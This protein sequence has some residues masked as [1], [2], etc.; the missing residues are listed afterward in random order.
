MGK[1]DEKGCVME[2]WKSVP[3]EEYKDYEVSDL[4]RI[5][6]NGKILKGSVNNHGYR[7]IRLGGKKGFTTGIHRL[8]ALA[9]V[10]NDDPE[11]KTQCNHINELTTD[12]RAVNL[13]WMTPKE[14]SNWGTGR[15]RS[16]NKHKKA[17]LQLDMDDN[18]IACY[19]SATDAEKAGFNRRKIS[20]VCNGRKATHKGFKWRFE[21]NPKNVWVIKNNCLTLWPV[22]HKVGEKV[23]VNWLKVNGLDTEKR[24]GGLITSTPTKL[25][26]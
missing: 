10:P 21:N 18:I 1:L 7:V 25:T 6:H 24:V 11:H 19:A 26:N 2:H 23:A 4:G 15:S 22:G 20:D 14:N 17:I 5:R 13:N 9:F 16:D 3:I 8:V 12:N